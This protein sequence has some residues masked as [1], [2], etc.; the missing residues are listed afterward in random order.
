MNMQ[1]KIIGVIG[2]GMMGVPMTN[3][4]LKA[5]FQVKGF[6]INPQAQEKIT[7]S[8]NFEW[9]NNPQEI[10][11]TCQIIILILPDS[12]IIDQLLWGN[13]QDGIV[14]HFQKD[15]L[16]IDM[17]SSRPTN[18]KTNAERLH[19]L[20]LS[21]IDAPV[22]GGVKRAIDGSLAIMIGGNEHDIQPVMPIFQALGKT[23]VHVGTAGAG[24][25]VKALNNY[26]SAAGL[27]AVSEAL[28]AA[29]KFGINP[30]LANQVFNASSGKNNTTEV[31]VENF[32]LS[33]TFNSGFAIA[34]M[35][36][37]IQTAKDFIHEMQSHGSF[38]QLCFD[39]WEGAEKSLPKGA[40]H[41][42]MFAYIKDKS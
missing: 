15:T 21:F 8:A 7:K 3:N 34:L 9:I 11:K 20:G 19:H 12:N 2:L 41:T 42:A 16:V 35:R 26:V 27:L 32:M 4:L 18:S 29:E 40:D 31:K 38:A 13:N 39:E 23:I 5:N 30:Y 36:K 10:A 1:N 28:V 25:A 24:H 37:D 17:S 14:S 6:D 33:E 22:S